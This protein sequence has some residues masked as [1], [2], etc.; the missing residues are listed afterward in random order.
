[1]NPE[2][3]L[4]EKILSFRLDPE[5]FVINAY[6][7]G[8]A[9]TP[10]QQSDGPRKWQRDFLN[11]LRSHV[12]ENESR[13]RLKL[14]PR[15]LRDATASGHGVGKSAL[16][17]W[18]AHWF[19][20]TRLGGCVNIAANSEDQL[21]YKTFAEISKW[22]SLALNSHWFKMEGLTVT[23]AAWFEKLLKDQLGIDSRGYFVRGHLW[24]INNPEAFQ[25]THNHIGVAWILDEASGVPKIIHRSIDPG[26]FTERTDSRFFFMFSNFTRN[27]GEFYDVFYG[28]E[29]ERWSTRH[30]DARDVEGLDHE[31]MHEM[32]AKLGEN[33]DRVRVR[34]TGLPPM[35]CEE[36]F[37][38]PEVVKAA[39]CRRIPFD[40]FAPKI[41]AVDPAP[42]GGNTAACIRE[43][44]HARFQTRIFT[45]NVPLANWVASL[46]DEEQ[47]DATF[48]DSGNGTGVIDI[49]RD[50]KYKIVEVLFGERA[51][52]PERFA[53]RRTEMW[54][55]VR[56]WL[57]GA[58][59]PDEDGLLTQLATPRKLKTGRADTVEKLES[60]K[61]LKARGV[62]SPDKADAL[63]MTFYK[64]VARLDSKGRRVRREDTIRDLDYQLIP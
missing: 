8:M 63:A 53:D 13:K 9:N 48:I 37:I 54:A 49:L 32:V 21:R 4:I 5:A 12:L 57:P 42:R 38:P 52:L 27:E 60:K 45:D 15:V 50:M 34:I 3:E 25:G 7:W 26:S 35:A 62:P 39:Q 33:H 47:P 28:S 6:P 18:I 44:R 14:V 51:D 22:T 58:E 20:S 61:Q 40:K 16:V 31:P 43:G 29:N 10:L 64:F 17:A 19:L 11:G 36:A 46:I 24:S 23:P 2:Q 41:L 55:G 1:M 30:I 59:L 56:G